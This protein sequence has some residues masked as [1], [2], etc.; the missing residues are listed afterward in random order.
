[1]GLTSTHNIALVLA[2]SRRQK[3]IKAFD[4]NLYCFFRSRRIGLCICLSNLAQHLASM[5]QVNANR[6]V[7]VKKSTMTSKITTTNINVL[8]SQN[9]PVFLYT[10]IPS[11]SSFCKTETLKLVKCEQGF[12]VLFCIFCQGFFD[13]ICQAFS[14]FCSDNGAKQN[15]LGLG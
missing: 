14:C 5:L 7:S 8:Q 15:A 9:L 4:E 12:F 1:M 13:N 2:L 3:I 11:E 6:S 10:S